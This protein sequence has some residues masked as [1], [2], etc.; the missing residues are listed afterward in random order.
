MVGLSL[1]VPRGKKLSLCWLPRANISQQLTQ[2]RRHFGFDNLSCKFLASLWM[3]PPCFLTNQ[4][5][6]ALTKEHQY[7]AHTKHIN[8]HF[9]FICWIIE[10][11]KLRLIYCPTKEMVADVLTKALVSMKVKHFVRELGLVMS[12]GGVLEWEILRTSQ[13]RAEVATRCMRCNY[14]SLWWYQRI[15]S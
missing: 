10:D 3:R 1:G 12:W 5:A 14:L 15:L 9:H 11:S 4:S 8:V 13:V 7:H 2:Q 6:I